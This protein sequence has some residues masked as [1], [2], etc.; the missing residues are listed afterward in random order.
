MKDSQKP[1]PLMVLT[2]VINKKSETLKKK[3]KLQPNSRYKISVVRHR[4]I[5]LLCCLIISMVHHWNEVNAN[6]IKHLKHFGY[7]ANKV[8]D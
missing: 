8:A 3:K 1:K 6:L 2:N 7:I 4:P 5:A